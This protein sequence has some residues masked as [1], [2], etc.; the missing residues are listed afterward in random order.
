M[1]GGPGSCFKRFVKPVVLYLAGGWDARGISTPNTV[2]GVVP[3]SV[4][5]VTVVATDGERV[6]AVIRHNAFRLTL[7]PSVGVAGERVTL[8][9]GRAFY[10]SDRVSG[11]AVK[12]AG[13]GQPI[14]R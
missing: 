12:P 11:T 14:H 6:R 13:P 7:P 10:V 8:R 9:N 3:N 1:K 5:A 2:W 4:A